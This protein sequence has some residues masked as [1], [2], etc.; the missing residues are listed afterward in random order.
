MFENLKNYISTKL[1]PSQPAIARNSGSH[2]S[3]VDIT[4]FRDAYR[5]IE[6]VHRC[7]DIIVGA[8][9]EIP[10]LVE[11]DSIR[12][13]TDKVNKLLNKYPNPNEDR[14]KLFRK[15]YL[16]YFVDGNVFFYYDRGNN[17]LY[18]LPANY[19]TIVPDEKVY[20]KKFIFNL[21]GNPYTSPFSVG[22][23]PSNTSVNNTNK[24]IEY[25]PEEIIHIK[26]DSTTSE[27]RGDSPLLSL[28]RL[29]D[30]Y[31]SLLGFQSQFFKNNAVPGLVLETDNVL[32]KTIK[33]RLMDHWRIAYNSS[34]NGAR[35]PAILDGGL[36]V[37]KIGSASLS[38]LDFEA[39]VERV[40]QDIS[41]ALGV[42]YVLL[43]SGNNANL[44]ANQKVFYTHTVLPVVNMFASAFQLFFSTDQASMDI[45]P[46]KWSILILQPDL[47]TQATYNSTL[48]N[49]GIITPDEARK[50]LRYDL[51]GGEMDQIRI[52]KNITGSATRP[53]TGGRPT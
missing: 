38:E 40:Q 4:S 18:H 45:F 26:A 16:D 53:D 32:S 47:K 2:I 13:P 19:V 9:S 34:F 49:A 51:K 30:L 6:I 36:K 10:F 29:F 23:G 28:T 39:S 24:T 43:K 12:P 37:N 41:K 8:C 11:A 7:L 52:P 33:D 14:L 35:S 5:D 42:P 21:G 46:D 22:I 17:K 50:E 48:V 1:N 3:P 44:D 27:F 25:T 15:A 20:I 31:N